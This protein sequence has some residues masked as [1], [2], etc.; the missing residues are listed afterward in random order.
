MLLASRCYIYKE[1]RRGHNYSLK[2]F[3]DLKVQITAVNLPKLENLL[4]LYNRIN[5]EKY[6]H[7]CLEYTKQQAILCR[8]IKTDKLR[9][10]PMMIHKITHF[11]DYKGW[12]K[13][14]D[15]QFN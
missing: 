2:P 9:Y 11:V 14:L 4:T 8:D 12:L 13:R 5:K 10:I 1:V 6:V 7:F 3:N 15:A